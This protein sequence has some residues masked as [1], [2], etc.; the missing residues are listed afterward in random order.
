MSGKPLSE[1]QTRK[2]LIDVQLAAAGWKVVPY[3]EHTPFATLN[4]VAVEEYPTKTGPADYALWIGGQLL[5]VVEAKKTSTAAQEVLSQA[6]RYSKG[7]PDV[8]GEWNGYRAPF[9]YSSN[10]QEIWYLDARRATNVRRKISAFH[11]P[12]AL[13][14]WF[15]RA[16]DDDFFAKLSF[17]HYGL[18][19]YQRE[20]V[21]AFESS[22]I[23]GKRELLIAMATGTGKTRTAVA[24]IHRQLESKNVRRV[25]FLVDRRALAAQTVREFG[26][27]QTPNGRQ[28]P[29]EYDVFHQQFR[30]E[31]MDDTGGYDPKILPESHLVN[32]DGSQTFVYVS[33][34]QRMAI[35]LFGHNAIFGG[36]DGESEDTDKLDIPSHAFDLIIADEC[37]RGYT[38]QE[39]G[40]WRQTIEHFDA[41]K[42]GLTAT[43]ATH[44]VALFKKPIYS[45][46]YAQAV[47]D[48][49]LCDFD[50]IKISSGVLMKGAFLKE[51]ELVRLRDRKTG[52][53]TDEVLEDE[54]QYD[55]G[56][57]E[58][59]ITVPDTNRKIV[60]ELYRHAQAHREQHGRWPKTLIFA[61]ND[62]GHTSHADQL[63]QMCREIF[64]QGDEFAVKITGNA[65]V[66]RPLQRI[67]EFRNRPNPTIVVTVDMLSTGVDIPA[68]EW[69]VF[70]RPVKSRIMWEQMLG[71]GTRRCP[72]IRKSKFTVFD[73]FDGTLISYFKGATDMEA[74]PRQS[75][76]SDEQVV[77]NIWNNYERKHYTNVL[78]KRLQRRAKELSGDGMM[79]LAAFDIPDG[80]LSCWAA[81]LPN[82]LQSD[83]QKTMKILRD[84][85][86][87]DALKEA[88]KVEKQFIVAIE[89]EDEVSSEVLFRV[90]AD[91]LRPADYL[92]KFAQY[93]REN[94]DRL[95]AIEILRER[96]REWN[97]E[98]LDELRAALQRHFFEENRLR[99]ATKLTGGKALA[100]TISL[101]KHAANAES[102][103][104]TAHER[105]EIALAKV[106][107]SR[108]FSLDAE[109]WLERIRAHLIENLSIELDDFNLPVFAAFGGL[110]RARRAFA[111]NTLQELVEEFNEAL[112]S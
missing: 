66:D 20:A 108:T 39:M 23:V 2:K 11:T 53:E 4:R 12:N 38:A 29:Q 46:T 101:V 110:G 6:K 8:I 58:R 9:L 75:S 59:D 67:R 73:C 41:I 43:P 90:G 104:F 98:A 52:G 112:A 82:L 54:R 50:A 5:G 77:E 56:K 69:I 97:R 36:G 44:T 35:N 95:A 94:P 28:F 84:P 64:C 24:L 92:E 60:E 106:R 18:R 16:L 30:R 42:L 3:N 79:R 49:T 32:P 48:G 14:E 62:I 25:L 70:L 13:V 47:A 7:L 105:V 19:P 81:S 86:F 107:I 80:D 33:T 85:N 100:D 88:T 96:P 51:G 27:F 103:L 89:Q 99:Q 71:R 78:V 31:D 93:V 45:Y 40:L 109:A 63:V 57:I 55:S 15:A 10:G 74:E 61:A 65:N 102:P 17:D 83:F 72:D 91:E 34:I 76:I 111:A 68:L 37:H 21:E 26:S 87:W 1:A 22:A